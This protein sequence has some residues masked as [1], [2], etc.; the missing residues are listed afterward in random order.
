ML[1]GGATNRC[2]HNVCR[3]ETIWGSDKPVEDEVR[4]LTF[5]T[6]AVVGFPICCIGILN[7][8][9]CLY[10]FLRHRFTRST[11]HRLIITGCTTDLIF[12][13]TNLLVCIESGVLRFPQRIPQQNHIHTI[14]VG[15]TALFIN[16]LQLFRTWISLLVGFER[17]LLISWP[18]FFRARW[19]SRTVNILV[20][21]CAFVVLAVRLPMIGI[22]V[23]DLRLD[24]DA[25]RLA[26]KIDAFIDLTF[27]T[28][29]PLTLLPL[30]TVAV[31]LNST[32]IYNWRGGSCVHGALKSG[33]AR[34]EKYESCRIT[35][36]RVHRAMMTV[37]TV[38]ILL[39]APSLP[40][41]ILR[42]ALWFYR[43]NK[44]CE[45]FLISMIM[46]AVTYV[47]ILLVSTVDLYIFM[48]CWS[49]FRRLLN[50]PLAWLTQKCRNLTQRLE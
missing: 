12:I 5:Y 6:V 15:I 30:M 28:L 26:Q 45:L 50:S 23:F 17:Y 43:S 18:I 42:L 44:N 46:D 16:C 19:R 24:C 31:A 4:V 32:R 25:A 29:I 3:N 48:A 20:V 34:V 11:T 36:L 22:I 8:I 41:V 40:N 14:V 1:K 37:L 2:N 7:N 33:V 49:R 47:C 13:I 10:I 27:Q 39:T 21:G 38:Y 35:T 9:I